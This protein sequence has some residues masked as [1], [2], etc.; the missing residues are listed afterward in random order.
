MER[1]GRAG[2]RKTLNSVKQYSGTGRYFEDENDRD[3]ADWND[4]SSVLKSTRKVNTIDFI[5]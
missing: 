2:L 1:I 5:L 3:K 4:L